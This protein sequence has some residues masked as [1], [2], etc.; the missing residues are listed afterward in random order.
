MIKLSNP[1][2]ALLGLLSEQPMYPYQIEQ[3]VKNRSMRYWADLSMSSIYK[4][5]R[6]LET[7]N[8][9]TRQNQ[10]SDGNRLQKLYSL[11]ETGKT[12]LQE[13]VE[14]ILS[15]PEHMRWQFDI[16]IY[17]SNLIPKGKVITA[18]KQYRLEL[19][20]KI[21]GYGELLDFLIQSKCPDYRLELANRPVLIFK[22]EIRWIDKYLSKIGDEKQGERTD[23]N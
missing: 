18:L 17:N 15:V 16:G 10:V 19:Q 5:L 22:S 12:V 13:K 4:L 8:L 9:V 21:K 11:S 1:E 2:T 7:E 23:E 6:K 14:E 20:K 3:E